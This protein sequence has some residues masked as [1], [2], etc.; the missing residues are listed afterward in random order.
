MPIAASVSASSFSSSSRCI[1]S[2]SACELAS[3]SMSLPKL[4]L[5]CS[6]DSKCVVWT[7]SSVFTRAARSLG[8]TAASA[9][10]MAAAANC[11]RALVPARPENSRSLRASL[12]RLTD[13]RGAAAAEA[14]GSHH[15]R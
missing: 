8:T 2:H 6:I 1:A 14:T 3:A 15:R 13:A 12:R 5:H 7:D 9:E 11:R 10:L 4:F